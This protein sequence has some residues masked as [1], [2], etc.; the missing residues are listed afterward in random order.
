LFLIGLGHP[1]LFFPSHYGYPPAGGQWNSY[2]PYPP[3]TGQ[4]I[5]GMFSSPEKTLEV[6]VPPYTSPL[7]AG[8]LFQGM[9]N[10]PWNVSLTSSSQPGQVSIFNLSRP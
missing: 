7:F 5:A 8:A 9:D 2:N 6:G 10:T 3:S 4:P 1:K